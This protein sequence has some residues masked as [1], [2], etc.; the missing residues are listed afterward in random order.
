[1]YN[2]LKGNVRMLTDSADI[3]LFGRYYVYHVYHL[4]LGLK[5]PNI[6]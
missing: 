3:L 5:K 2:E 6:C 1:M 4:S